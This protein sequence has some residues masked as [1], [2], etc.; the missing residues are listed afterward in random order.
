[1]RFVTE[2][3]GFESDQHA[4]RFICEHGGEDLLTETDGEVFLVTGT[5]AQT[6]FEQ[7]RAQA[8]KTVDIK[9]QV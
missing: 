7:A 2:E 3:L 8:F 5:K 4:A 6:I 9:G 1:L